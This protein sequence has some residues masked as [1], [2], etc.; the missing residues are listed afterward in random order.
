MFDGIL[1]ALQ[2]RD[3]VGVVG[4]VFLLLPEVRHGGVGV[5]T[6]HGPEGVGVRAGEEDV[7][8]CEG[9]DA[10]VLQ[11]HHRLR[12]N[13]VGC[14]TLLGR[15]E[16]DLLAAIEVGV[17]VE[18]S[19]TELL[20]QHVL[21]GTLQH[22]GLHQSLVDGLLQVL[23]VGTEGEIDIVAAIDGC[24]CLV[25]DVLQIGNLVDGGV[26]AHHHTVETD[27]AAQD[28]H[29]DLAVG[30]TPRVVHVVIARHDDLAARQ[31]DHGLVRQQNLLHQL[32]LVSIT[33]AA[34]AEVVF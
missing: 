10:V 28:V 32:F 31:S 25:N 17:L 4:H 21:D 8:R 23:V 15:V 22:F 19:G 11:Q 5:V 14:L 30:H 3:D 24:C 13:V 20:A 9:Q 16:G 26:V 12:S 6:T 18:Q 2:Q 29:Q 27:I 7:F 1:H 34:I 33:A